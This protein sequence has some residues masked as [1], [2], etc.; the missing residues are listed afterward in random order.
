MNQNNTDT[1]QDQ[2][3]PLFDDSVFNETVVSEPGESSNESQATTPSDAFTQ[4]SGEEA[5]LEAPSQQETQPLEA[6]NDD[7]RYQYWQ[8]QSAKKDN[9]I[10]EMRAQLNQVQQNVQAQTQ[11]GPQQATAPEQP[12]EEFPPPPEKPARPRTFNRQEAYEDAS[13]DSARYLDEMDEWR[14][15]MDEYNSLKSQYDS[16]LIQEKYQKMEEQQQQ[17]S[18]VAEAQRKQADQIAQVSEFVQGNYGMSQEE[19]QDFIQTMSDPSSITVDNLVKLYRLEKGGANTT[20]AP[21]QAQPSSAFQQTQRAQAVPSPMGV[22]PTANTDASQNSGDKIMDSI[23]NDYNN[24]NP[25][26]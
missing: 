10:R 5:P 1:S 9:E 2:A 21:P 14:D 24:N 17:A 6:K 7:K 16:A 26:K 15:T 3:N 18:R 25:W 23:I 8:S 20:S 19:T 22:Q 4:P 11:Q 12:V 13:S